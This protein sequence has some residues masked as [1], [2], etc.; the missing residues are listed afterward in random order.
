MSPKLN[1]QY[2]ENMYGPV[3]LKTILGLRQQVSPQQVALQRWLDDLLGREPGPRL[4]LTPYNQWLE[5]TH[6]LVKYL[7]EELQNA[8]MTG[9][10]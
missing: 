8:G 6:P 1:P 5:G 7:Y 2:A 9:L 10:E 4:S 3:D